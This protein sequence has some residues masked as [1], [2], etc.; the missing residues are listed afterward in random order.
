MC[1]ELPNEVCTEYLVLYYGWPSE[2][3]WEIENVNP[4]RDEDYVGGPW[5]SHFQVHT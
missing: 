1:S 2:Y 4:E 5:V 3:G